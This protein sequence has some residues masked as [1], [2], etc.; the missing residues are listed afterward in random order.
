MSSNAAPGAADPDSPVG[1]GPDGGRGRF[2]P[3]FAS[4]PAG[5]SPDVAVLAALVADVVAAEA[6]VAAAEVARVRALAAIGQFAADAAQSARASVRASEMAMRE[7]ASEV[8]AASRASDRTVQREIGDAMTLVESYPRTVGAWEAGAI[9]RRHV[10][11]IADAGA[12]LP[13]ERRAQFDALAVALAGEVSSPGRLKSRLAAASQRLHPRTVT[14]RH[15][16]AREG[17][18]VRVVP[19]AEGMS[20]LIATLPT[21]LAEAIHDRVTQQARVIVDGRRDAGAEIGSGG[22]AEGDPAAAPVSPVTNA[23]TIDQVRAD[24][25]ADMLLTGDPALDPTRFGD[26]PGTL[27]KIRARV[28]VVVPALT[29]LAPS[30]ENAAPAELVGRGPIDA[31]TARRLA[32]ATSVPW[33]RVITHPVVG[34]VLHTDTYQRTTG[35]DRH[36]RA[37]DRRCRWPGCTAP[38][39]R[40]EID[41]TTEWA[42]GGRTEVG[43]LACLCQRHH[44]QKQ[45]TRWTVRQLPGG[46]LEWT[47]PTGRKYTDH[48]DPYAPGYP[49]DAEGPTVRFEH[50]PPP[51]EGRTSDVDDEPETSGP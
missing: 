43:N 44:T 3:R 13:M 49:P 28:Q 2:S 11:I 41:H 51:W 1:R 5:P 7:V 35:I 6:A 23:R 47:S 12:G 8:A 42:K 33:D 37:R 21:V 17:R 25:F 40:C 20:D 27:G 26:G 16:A 9:S 14:E 45:F 50:D 24:V 29:M 48:P 30:G 36:L 39:I 38:A 34:T 10:R 22:R 19:G 4:H 18:C 32:E 31:D 15:R 46:L